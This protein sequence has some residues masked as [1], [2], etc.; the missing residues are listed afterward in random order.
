MIRMSNER[1]EFY[2]WGRDDDDKVYCTKKVKFYVT[3]EDK[4]DKKMA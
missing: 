4:D 2:P 1:P 3:E